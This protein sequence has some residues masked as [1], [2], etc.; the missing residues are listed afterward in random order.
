MVSKPRKVVVFL[1]TRPEG[2]KLAPVI[3]ALRRCPDL[4]TVVVS[5]GQHRE[6]LDQVV[7]LFGIPV[8][9]DLA[10]MQPDQTLASLTARLISR[11]ELVPSSR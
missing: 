3:D 11:I 2:V 1:G 6:M 9:A 7:R 10:V 8:D 4:R 5:T